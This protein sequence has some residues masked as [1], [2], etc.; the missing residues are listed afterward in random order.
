MTENIIT[1]SRGAASD[2]HYYSPLSNVSC[3]VPHIGFCTSQR[4]VLCYKYYG[5][6]LSPSNNN[7]L[8]D[9]F[10]RWDSTATTSSSSRS[11]TVEI[12][13]SHISPIILIMPYPTKFKQSMENKYSNWFGTYTEQALRSSEIEHRLNQ[14]QSP[15]QTMLAVKSMKVSSEWP[16]LTLRWAPRHLWLYYSHSARVSG[17][18]RGRTS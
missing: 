6:N 2:W 8:L 1:V 16:S 12:M 4:F 10:L 15:A 17:R 11:L 13:D 7:N 3:I 14:R 5:L 9:R 18:I